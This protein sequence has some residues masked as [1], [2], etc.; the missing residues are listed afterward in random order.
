MAKDCIMFSIFH[1]QLEFCLLT[2]RDYMYIE[3][4]YKFHE[5]QRQ[6]LHTHA[7]ELEFESGLRKN[8]NIVF[9]PVILKAGS[10]IG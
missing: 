3:K 1:D 7:H 9:R 2:W 8:N 6:L 4:V 5:A 10:G